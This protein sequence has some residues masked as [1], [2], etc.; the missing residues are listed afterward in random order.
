MERADVAD[1][2]AREDRAALESE[3][4]EQRAGRQVAELD[5]GRAQVALE[6]EQRLRAQLER[7]LEACQQRVTAAEKARD[8]AIKTLEQAAARGTSPRGK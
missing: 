6:G 5:R 4:A 3:L 1:Q 8:A 7:D 2:R